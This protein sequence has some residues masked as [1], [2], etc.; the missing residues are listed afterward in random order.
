MSENLILYGAV[1]ADVYAAL[2]DLEDFENLSKRELVGAYDAA[3]I[4]VPGDAPHIVRRMRRPTLELIPELVGRGR[5]PIGVL[6]EPLAPGES[7]LVV[8]G[9]AELE[10][11]FKHAAGRAAFTSERPLAPEELGAITVTRSL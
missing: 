3:V 6:P 10:K 9:S 11:G 1:H 5:P 7:A 8:I 4:D 2:A